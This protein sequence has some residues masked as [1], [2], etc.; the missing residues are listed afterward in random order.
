MVPITRRVDRLPGPP[1]HS[2]RCMRAEVW[3]GAPR[4]LLAWVRERDRCEEG[5]ACLG[6]TV[7][8]LTTKAVRC[9]SPLCITN[10]VTL[11]TVPLEDDLK[12]FSN[13]E[14]SGRNPKLDWKKPYRTSPKARIL[15]ISHSHAISFQGFGLRVPEPFAHLRRTSSTRYHKDS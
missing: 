7:R 8:S 14:P 6:Y 10:Q 2:R 5:L 12:L 4:D 9:F 3:R 13:L 1:C 15:Q 11:I